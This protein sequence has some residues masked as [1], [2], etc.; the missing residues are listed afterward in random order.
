MLLPTVVRSNIQ[1]ISEVFAPLVGKR[2]LDVGCGSGGLIGALLKRGAI[3]VGVDR[4]ERAVGLA[5]ARFPEADTYLGDFT[6]LPFEDAAFDGAI[7]LNCLGSVPAESTGALL[8]ES[9]RVVKTRGKVLVIEPQS[10]GG[11]MSKHEPGSTEPE[12]RVSNL[13]GLDRFLAEG[14]ASEITRLAYSAWT[15]GEANTGL[16][17]RHFADGPGHDERDEPGAITLYGRLLRPQEGPSPLRQRMLASI[18][19]RP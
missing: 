6:A 10:E 2:L 1:L 7:L 18:Y 4:S 14:Y 11:A 16:T 19:T 13:S 5:R 12:G 3:A 17:A 15:S 9:L 8:G